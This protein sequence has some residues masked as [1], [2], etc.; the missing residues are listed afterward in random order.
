M[1]LLLVDKE[2]KIMANLVSLIFSSTERICKQAKVDFLRRRVSILVTFPLPHSQT[3]SCSLLLA[4]QGP[5]NNL[6]VEEMAY[7]LDDFFLP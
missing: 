4:T 5:E 6:P 2:E 7:T 3:A 1:N